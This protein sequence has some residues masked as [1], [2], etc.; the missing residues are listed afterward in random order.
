MELL[1]TLLT[2]C[3]KLCNFADDRHWVYLK[4]FDAEK[5]LNQIH[6]KQITTHDI[7]A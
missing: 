3:L 7:F 5:R 1:E 2:K 4:I 6:L